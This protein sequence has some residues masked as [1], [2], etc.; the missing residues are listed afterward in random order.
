MSSEVFGYSII[1]T[2]WTFLIYIIWSEREAEK[3]REAYSYNNLSQLNILRQILSSQQEFIKHV[4][5]KPLPRSDAKKTGNGVA[6]LVK[7][8]PKQ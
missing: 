7:D 5:Q 1:L 8:L 6:A 4:T 2:I 3:R